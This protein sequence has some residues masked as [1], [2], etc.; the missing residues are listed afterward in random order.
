MSVLDEIRDVLEQISTKMDR[1]PSAG[2]TQTLQSGAMGQ[3]VAAGP[4]RRAAMA[5][6]AATGAVRQG[7]EAKSQGSVRAS[8]AALVGRVPGG[9]AVAGVIGSS[10]ILAGA[11]IAALPFAINR[12]NQTLSGSSPQMAAIQGQA[13]A[14]NRL[15]GQRLGA[16]LAPT[17]SFLSNQIQAFKTALEP[18]IVVLG[19]LFNVVGGLILQGLEIVVRIL[20]ITIV[21]ILEMIADLLEQ[22][23]GI[24]KD[25]PPVFL[26]ELI[27]QVGSG[28]FRQLMPQDIK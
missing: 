11:A 28:R 3:T 1:P 19:R 13:E 22:W 17:A 21:P 16:A 23:L 15:R 8:T 14:Q 20:E 6:A 25:K 2:T 10:G 27:E 24:S 7:Q 12:L 18:V 26:N 5:T 9:G 4:S